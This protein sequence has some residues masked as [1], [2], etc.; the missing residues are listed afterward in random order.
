M[1]NKECAK[2]FPDNVSNTSYRN[3]VCQCHN[4]VSL[5]DLGVSVRLR[6]RGQLGTWLCWL[7]RCAVTTHVIASHA[8]WWEI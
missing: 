5:G 3:M 6:R 4:P 7:S 2:W 1:V 8:S